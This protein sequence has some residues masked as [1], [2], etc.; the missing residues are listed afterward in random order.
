MLEEIIIT[1]TMT[2]SSVAS[3]F[4][5]LNGNI[6][7]NYSGISLLNTVYKIYTRVL[8]ERLSK[9]FTLINNGRTKWISSGQTLHG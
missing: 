3:V 6:S 9:Y 1:K 8:N 4:K 5:K 2:R 7:G